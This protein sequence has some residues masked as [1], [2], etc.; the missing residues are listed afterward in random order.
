MTTITEPLAAS[1]LLPQKPRPEEKKDRPQDRLFAATAQ[2]VNSSE[3]SL[4]V[5]PVAESWLKFLLM[6]TVGLQR[7]GASEG[8]FDQTLTAETYR[9]EAQG[10]IDYADLQ[11]YARTQLDAYMPVD[12]NPATY[13]STNEVVV[14]FP[15][16]TLVARGDVFVDRVGEADQATRV[17][18]VPFIKLPE[19]T[20]PLLGKVRFRLG[21]EYQRNLTTRDD[22]LTVNLK[23]EGTFRDQP[24]WGWGVQV[25]TAIDIEDRPEQKDI[26]FTGLYA[27]T[28]GVVGDG[29]FV[30]GGI[31]LGKPAFEGNT[32]DFA[33]AIA[34]GAGV[35]VKW[36][37]E[38]RYWP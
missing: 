20:I 33:K 16:E 27:W 7:Q 24:W 32:Q 11:F 1:P 37:T 17:A 34:L 30:E 18:F 14:K 4:G 35:K 29:A 21:P 22:S 13:N 9:L 19:I 10:E 2:S 31:W 6:G 23:V 15:D 38:P 5:L 12:G 3:F 25:F 36:G 8:S 28:G 26:D